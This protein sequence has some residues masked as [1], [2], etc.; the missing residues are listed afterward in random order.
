ME[1]IRVLC[2]DQ[3]E[4]QCTCFSSFLLL[5]CNIGESVAD[6]TKCLQVIV[7]V[8]WCYINKTEEN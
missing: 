2:W 7:V 3:F 1:L 6:N 5:L 8:N 4:S